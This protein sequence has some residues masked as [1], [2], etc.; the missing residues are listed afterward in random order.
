MRPLNPLQT[1]LAEIPVDT[2]LVRIRGSETK[3][4]QF[5]Q[6]DASRTV[7]LVHGFRGTHHGLA[8]LIALM[9]EVRFLAPD[10]PGFGE[11]TPLTGEHSVAEYAA[12]L[13]ELLRIVDPAG[14]STVLGHSFGSMIV[15]KAAAQIGG[16]D[17]ILVNP[18][19]E[20]ALKGPDRLLTNLGIF[21][22]WAGASLPRPL[23]N[24][25]LSS[26]LITRVMSEVMTVTK[27]RALRQWIH[28]EHEEHF[29]DFANRDVLLEAFRASVSTDVTAFA[30]DLP[31][32][33]TLIVGERD[34]IA[35]LDAAKRL[36]ARMPESKLHVIEG[37]GHLV[38][39]ETPKPLAH[40]VREHLNEKA[41]Q[42]VIHD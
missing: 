15:A 17:I 37:V 6:Q 19:A 26:R 5:G 18:I 42:G 2:R 41:T 32:G 10:L 34:M 11:S 39:Y 36:F 3:L 1:R 33:T 40:V 35:P 8:N 38:H 13:L 29:S 25:L 31:T 24:A 23:G 7:L 9:P 28:E 14:S 16:R 20:N 21:Y 4:W 27:H 12:W 22:Y 30:G